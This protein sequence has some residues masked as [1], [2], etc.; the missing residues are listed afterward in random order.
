MLDLTLGYLGRLRASIAVIVIIVLANI[1]DIYHDLLEGSSMTHIVE[2]SIMVLIFF[3][4]IFILTKKLFMS[5]HQL[6]T[7]N[8]ELKNIK[9]L[10]EQQTNEMK[11]A[12]KDYSGVIQ[13]QFHQWKLTNTESEIGFLLLK[14]LSLKEIA[15]VRGV[16]EKTSR[17]QASNIYAKAGVAG[18][19]EFA[20]WFFEEL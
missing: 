6:E 17:Q 16:K 14:G 2:E 19:H 3:T 20:G 11:Q 10:H 8:E 4:I 18:R 13:D 5:V 9:S 12:R 1:I 7:V 15:S